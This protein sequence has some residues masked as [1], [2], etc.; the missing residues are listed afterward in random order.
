[1]IL[2]ACGNWL[3]VGLLKP[4]IEADIYLGARK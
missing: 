4:V 2:S 3:Y 1:M